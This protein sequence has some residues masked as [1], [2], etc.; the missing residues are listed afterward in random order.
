M[1]EKY[2]KWYAEGMTDMTA[3]KQSVIIQLI[4][5]DD[6]YQNCL[7]LAGVLQ[8]NYNPKKQKAAMRLIGGVTRI[9]YMESESTPVYDFSS[10]MSEEQVKQLEFLFSYHR[11]LKKMRKDLHEEFSKVFDNKKGLEN[12]DNTDG[13]KIEI[14]T[15]EP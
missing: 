12:F 13:R 7:T 8:I 15:V 3:M 6:Q 10:E 2:K 14:L 5:C 11:N 4:E 9:K 1:G